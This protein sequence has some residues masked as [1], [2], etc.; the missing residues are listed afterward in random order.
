MPT[1]TVTP[2]KRH[3]FIGELTRLSFAPS[4]QSAT[5]KVWHD[6]KP[7]FAGEFFRGADGMITIWDLD[8]IL[9]PYIS[10]QYADFMFTVH[11]EPLTS[12]YVS[13]F[14][15]AWSL[16]VPASVFLEKRFL[17]PTD[18]TRITGPG[19][20]EPLTAFCAAPTQAKAVC[21]YCSEDG[22]T[23]SAEVQ[24]GEV[25]GIGVLNVSPARFE[26]MPKGRLFAY[27]VVCGERKADYIVEK[28]LPEL[29][30][31]FIFRNSFNAW[32]T[33]Y[34]CGTR[35]VE[36]QY[37][38]LSADVDG[39]RRNY[40]INEVLQLKTYT[41]P[42]LPGMEWVAMSLARSQAV[43][44]LLPNGDSGDEILVNDCDLKHDNS[45]GSPVDLTFSYRTAS[46]SYRLADDRV[47]RLSIPRPPR[48]FDD[49]FDKT[50]E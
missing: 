31:A 12:H 44:L 30:D 4:S 19:R 6:G 46:V 50:Y 15:C 26:N 8:Q 48:I 39:Y 23:S 28:S 49:S 29:S 13:V 7:I 36:P 43:F 40:S 18:G 25:S 35:T 41:G 17:T 34:L 24:L 27:S 38:R 47:A 2:L 45:W 5:F 10:E 14:Y 20:H 9:Q 3:M 22:A 32:D 1:V 16:D 33:I 11:D 21:L 37:T 42:L